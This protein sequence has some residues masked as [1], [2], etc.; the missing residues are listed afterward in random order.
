[1]MS[2]VKPNDE[3]GKLPTSQR[4]LR[5][6]LIS[7][8]SR[9]STTARACDSKSRMLMLRMA[10]R[11]PQEWEIDTE[12]LGNV[13]GRERDPELQCLRVDFD[14]AVLLAMLPATER[15][16]ERRSEALPSCNLAITSR[17]AS[18]HGRGYHRRGADL[19]AA[20]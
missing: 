16:M 10:E 7:G 12:D 9:R 11:L 20:P 8:S 14:G 3:N 15:I 4:P 5:V 17:P 1:M 18:C 6:L 2:D 19:P 13:Y